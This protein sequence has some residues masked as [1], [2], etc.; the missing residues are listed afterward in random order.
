MLPLLL[1][2]RQRLF[3]TRRR[4]SA[5]A[6]ACPRF[7]CK[8]PHL[9]VLELRFKRLDLGMVLICTHLRLALLVLL[10]KRMVELAAQN[11]RPERSR[12]CSVQ[13]VAAVDRRRPCRRRCSRECCWLLRQRYRSLRAGGGKQFW[14]E[15]DG[16]WQ[17]R[18][19][20]NT[21]RRCFC[22]RLHQ[23]LHQRE[24]F[25][26]DGNLLRLQPFPWDWCCVWILRRSWQR[27]LRSRGRSR[28]GHWQ[29][30]Q[31]FSWWPCSGALAVL[32]GNLGIQKSFGGGQRNT[33]FRVEGF[34]IDV[35][36]KVATGAV[37][38]HAWMQKMRMGGLCKG[39]ERMMEKKLV[40]RKEKVASGKKKGN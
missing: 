37:R 27:R 38:T 12:Q 1:L 15:L 40:A 35:V 14:V 9:N 23:L 16:H 33:I 21:L 18:N 2:R 36:N 4:P 19:R 28:R 13:V 31:C 24:A 7:R 25:Q 34:S 11:G 22:S 20:G 17:L 29:A 6:F 39:E 26:R 5:A 10:R 3:E 8:R 32:G 30:N